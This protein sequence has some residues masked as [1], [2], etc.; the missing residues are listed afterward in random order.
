MKNKT[1]KNLELSLSI[2]YLALGLVFQMEV[3]IFDLIRHT[4]RLCY[5]K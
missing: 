1:S 4:D 5:F 3:S 2:L